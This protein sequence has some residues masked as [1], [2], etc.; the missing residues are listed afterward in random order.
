MY[1]HLLY[2]QRSKLIIMPLNEEGPKLPYYLVAWAATTDGRKPPQRGTA[3][4]K[5]TLQGT[6]ICHVSTILGTIFY[7]IGVGRACVRARL[8]SFKLS[9]HGRLRYAI[10]FL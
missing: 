3:R 9:L 10:K 4:E 2:W 7:Q 6:T 8:F 1:M 5:R